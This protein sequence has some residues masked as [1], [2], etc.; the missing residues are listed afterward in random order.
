MFLRHLAFVLPK[1]AS[2]CHGADAACHAA[3]SLYGG[4]VVLTSAAG[5]S[6]VPYIGWKGDFTKLDVLGCIAIASSNLSRAPSGL[7]SCS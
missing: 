6:R 4:W 5:A 1:H 3:Q 2:C 7:S